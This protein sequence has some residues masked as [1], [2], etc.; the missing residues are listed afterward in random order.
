M[1]IVY[2]PYIKGNV[3]RIMLHTCSTVNDHAN[4]PYLRS[5]CGHGISADQNRT[6]EVQIGKKYK[7][8]ACGIEKLGPL[9]WVCEHRR[10]RGDLAAMCVECASLGMC[11]DHGDK[12]NL[13]PTPTLIPQNNH[14]VVV[15][16]LFCMKI[17]AEVQRILK[18]FG[19]IPTSTLYVSMHV[20]PQNR[21]KNQFYDAVIV[22]PDFF[23]IVIQNGLSGRTLDLKNVNRDKSFV[24]HGTSAYDLYNMKNCTFRC[25]INISIPI[26]SDQDYAGVLWWLGQGACGPPILKCFLSGT[27][28]KQQHWEIEISDAQDSSV[29][30]N[31]K[32][33]L[34][35][36]VNA[37]HSN[38]I[39]NRDGQSITLRIAWPNFRT[40]LHAVVNRWSY[41]GN[42]EDTERGIY[43]ICALCSVPIANTDTPLSQLE[44]VTDTSKDPQL[45]CLLQRGST[46][47][48]FLGNTICIRCEHVC[49]ESHKYIDQD[50][51]LWKTVVGN[52]EE[53]NPK[54]DELVRKHFLHT[55]PFFSGVAVCKNVLIAPRTRG[56]ERKLAI[57]IAESTEHGLL[58]A[59]VPVRQ[60]NYFLDGEA[61]ATTATPDATRHPKSLT[62]NVKFDEFLKTLNRL[63]NI[64]I[65]T[66]RIFYSQAFLNVHGKSITDFQLLDEKVYQIC[67]FFVSTSVSW[68][69]ILKTSKKELTDLLQPRLRVALETE[70][71]S[72]NGIFYKYISRLA[73]RN[74]QIVSVYLKNEE[75]TQNAADYNTVLSIEEFRKTYRVENY[76]E[77]TGDLY[78]LFTDPKTCTRKY[79]VA[80]S[81]LQNINIDNESSVHFLLC[82]VDSKEKLQ[83]TTLPPGTRDTL[84]QLATETKKSTQKTCMQLRC[85]GHIAFNYIQPRL[86]KIWHHVPVSRLRSDFLYYIWDLYVTTGYANSDPNVLLLDIL[87]YM[88]PKDS[89]VRSVRTSKNPG[90]IIFGNNPET[91]LDRFLL[92]LNNYF[93]LGG[94][95][96]KELLRIAQDP[97]IDY[98]EI[99]SN[100][101]PNL[102]TEAGIIGKFVT[103]R[104]LWPRG[105][106]GM[107]LQCSAGLADDPARYGA[108]E[109]LRHTAPVPR[110]IFGV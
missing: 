18:G 62:K 84:L 106:R 35:Q 3:C 68:K 87:G 28:I 45:D 69:R 26:K 72:T 30:I 53:K 49:K 46:K 107:L 81:V 23:G 71:Q 94:V 32:E 24:R 108:I 1:I 27:S 109:S 64:N 99:N 33:T 37:D 74:D 80:S 31:Y 15:T 2:T 36:T 12:R 76:R 92:L 59:V 66:K 91:D 67:A 47:T 93:R 39:K 20:K 21:R 103:R 58:P 13:K 70:V 88:F 97:D 41:P 57:I 63:E 105:M 50:M 34:D 43:R 77:Q 56:T 90:V 17:A 86:E 83:S 73:Y 95:F 40:G 8:D 10:P 16:S 60:V 51:R 96:S 110:D 4:T 54:M 44:A 82:L 42:H 98:L 5:G 89:H 6:C 55:I 78:S 79:M 102:R 25:A 104:D 38:Q 19:A 85:C 52:V 65:Q 75:S 11:E 48:T 100:S 9:L 29:R 14:E 101:R 7:C 22:V 61:Q